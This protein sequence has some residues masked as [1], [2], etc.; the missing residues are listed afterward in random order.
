M[1]VVDLLQ[2]FNTADTQGVSISVKRR[3]AKKKNNPS[4]ESS[5]ETTQINGTSAQNSSPKS[6]LGELTV[7]QFFRHSS[8]R[9]VKNI[10]IH[11]FAIDLLL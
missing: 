11:K 3:S 1:L 5:P 6:V 9:G 4:L 10:L 2:F 7:S 8:Q